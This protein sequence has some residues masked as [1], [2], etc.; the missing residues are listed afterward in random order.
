MWGPEITPR[1]S[2]FP[3]RV[4]AWLE[5]KEGSFHPKVL[6]AAVWQVRDALRR[7]PQE[8]LGK[9]LGLQ[10]LENAKSLTLRF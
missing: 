3:L 1:E 5:T 4:N 9:Y 6:T 2:E 8:A 7:G 10:T